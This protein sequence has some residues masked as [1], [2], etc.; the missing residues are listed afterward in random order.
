[1]PITVPQPKQKFVVQR[2]DSVDGDF[3]DG[4]FGFIFQP[5]DLD[6]EQYAA[7]RTNVQFESSGWSVGPHGGFPLRTIIGDTPRF[8][9]RERTE[10]K[11][12]CS[13]LAKGVPDHP[14]TW[15]SVILPDHIP[16]FC[17]THYRLRHGKNSPFYA[18][19][20]WRLLG[21]RDGGRWF[22]IISH[23]DENVL[24]GPEAVATFRIYCEN[25]DFKE[26]LV[27]CCMPCCSTVIAPLVEPG[28]RTDR[29]CVCVWVQSACAQNLR[30][31]VTNSRAHCPC[32]YTFVGHSCSR[33]DKNPRN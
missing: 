2:D 6:D 3:H 21:S 11:R 24:C 9:N 26:K 15:F 30:P 29:T 28:V 32:V 23:Q 17:P 7:Q 33:G 4:F 31:F 5:K 22:E 10:G 27:R 12:I 20:S 25:I 19:R 14:K 8:A 13:S 16:N 18:M 1:M